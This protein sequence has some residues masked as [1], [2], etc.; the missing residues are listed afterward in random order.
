MLPIGF[1]LLLLLLLYFVGSGGGL[2]ILS[3]LSYFVIDIIVCSKNV[4]LY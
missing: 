3:K 2:T 4:V 1:L